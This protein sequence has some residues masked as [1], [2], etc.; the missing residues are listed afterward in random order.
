MKIR[1]IKYSAPGPRQVQRWK[2]ELGYTGKQMSELVNGDPRHWRRHTGGTEPRPITY[3]KLF[4]A[5]AILVLSTEQI[6][7]VHA[8][9]REI[10]AVVEMERDH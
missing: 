1:S 4:H 10:G 6:E 8:H 5:A 9:M 7:Q 2:E 3:T